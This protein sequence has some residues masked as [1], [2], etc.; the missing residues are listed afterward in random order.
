MVPSEVKGKAMRN[1][2]K[3]QQNGSEN[4]RHCPLVESFYVATHRAIIVQR[5]GQPLI[6]LIQQC[7]TLK[8]HSNYCSAGTAAELVMIITNPWLQKR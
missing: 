6:R 3:R 7:N 4:N 5:L 1:R 8:P 2:A